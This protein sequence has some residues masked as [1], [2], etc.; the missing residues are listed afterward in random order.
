LLQSNG[1]RGT[2]SFG[3]KLLELL[4]K[5]IPYYNSLLQGSALLS[6]NCCQL[7]PILI[8]YYYYYYYSR[9]QK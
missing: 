6:P 9:E 5:L 3:K 8:N 2:Y 4:L 1:T 7:V